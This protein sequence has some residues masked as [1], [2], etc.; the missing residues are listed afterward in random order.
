M[1]GAKKAKK[2]NAVRQNWQIEKLATAR[3]L[4]AAIKVAVDGESAAASS[5]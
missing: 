4:G 2:S 3:W 1:D 5:N